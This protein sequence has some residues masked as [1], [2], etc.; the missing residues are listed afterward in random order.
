M[1]NPHPSSFTPLCFHHLF[2]QQ[3]ARHPNAPAILFEDSLIPYAE[4][5]RNANR[6]ARH[7]QAM[8]IG[9]Q[10]LVAISMERAPEMICAILGIFKAGAAWV[11]LDPLLPAARKALILQETGASVILTHRDLARQLPANQATV[12]SLDHGW[13]DKLPQDDSNPASTHPD[14]RNHLAYIIYTSGSTGMPKGVL[15]EQGGLFNLALAQKSIFGV[16]A[17]DRVLQ[18]SSLNFDASIFEIVM[19]L[20]AGATLVLGR[21]EAILPGPDL[22]HFLQTRAVSH[23]TIP[24]SSL[25]NLPQGDLPDLRTL[26]LAGEVL[27]PELAARWASGRRLFNAYGPT[28]TTVWASVAQVAADGSKPTLGFAIPN[29]QL[30]LLDQ[31]QQAVA[32]GEVGEIT[33]GG[34]GVARGY[35]LRPELNRK[36]FLPNPHHPG[37]DGKP[38]SRMYRS[39]DLGRFL[40][41]GSLEFLGRIDQQIKLRGYRI[42]P[43]EIETVLKQHAGVRDALVLARSD[44]SPQSA[45]ASAANTATNPAENLAENSAANPANSVQLL[46]WVIPDP[47]WRAPPELLASWQQE[48]AKAWQGLYDDTYTTSQQELRLEDDFSGWGNS[49]TGQPIPEQEMREWVDACVAPVL[50]LRPQRVL[51]IGCGSGLLARRIAAQ[52]QHYSGIDISAA[53]ISA[54]EQRL[55]HAGIHNVSLAVAAADD[56]AAVMPGRFD[57]IIINSVLQY[58][59]DADYLQQVLANAVRAC[60]PGGFVF[61]GDVRNLRL[62][63]AFYSAIECYQRPHLAGQTQ[64]LRQRIA[65]RARAEEELLVDPAFFCAL[66]ASLPEISHVDIRLRRGKAHNELT[67][68]RYNVLLHVATDP[69]AKPASSSTSATTAAQAAPVFHTPTV[70]QGHGIADLPAILTSHALALIRIPNARLCPAHPQA[71]DP[72]SVAEL[73]SA[74]GYTVHLSWGEAADHFNAWF[75]RG[76]AAATPFDV[77]SHQAL[78]TPPRYTNHPLLLKLQSHL[79]AELRAHL[80]ARLPPHMVPAA[81]VLIDQFP[82]NTSGKVDVNAL[83]GPGLRHGRHQI[84]PR[85]PLE[86]QL[87]AIWCQLLGLESVGIHDNFFE[88]GGHSLLA[89]QLISRISAQCEFRLQTKNIFT[90]PTIAELVTLVQGQPKERHDPILPRAVQLARRGTVADDAAADDAAAALPLSF[91]QQRL[92]FLSQLT[93][94]SPFYNIPVALRLD[95]VLNVAALQRSLDALIARHEILR[96]LFPTHNGQARQQIQP[97]LQITLEQQDISQIEAQAEAIHDIAAEHARAPFDLVLG[98]LLRAKLLRCSLQQDPQQH[99]QQHPQQ[100]RQ[101]Y[102][103]LLLTMHHIISDAWSMAI[104]TRELADFY[105][106]ASKPETQPDPQ[107]DPASAPLAPAPLQYADFALWQR[108]QRDPARMAQELAYWRQRLAGAPMVLELPTDY[109]RPANQAFRGA[110]HTVAISAAKLAQLQALSQDANATLFMTLLAAFNVL[111]WRSSGQSDFL[112]GTPIAGRNRVETE[113]MIGFFVNSL[114]LR[115]DLG[116]DPE[117]RQHL[118]SVKQGALDAFAHKDLP[119]EK[120]VEELRPQ[121]DLSRNALFQVM[122]VLQNAP[123]AAI[124]RAGLRFSPQVIDNHT[125]K[126]DL[127]LTLE[128][129]G[130]GLSA[131]LEYNTDLFSAASAQRMLG[132]YVNLLDAIIRQPDAKVSRL[133]LLGSQEQ[134]QLLHAWNHFEHQFAPQSTIHA[135][136]ETQARTRPDACAIRCGASRLSYAELDQRANRLAHWL[137]AH[138]VTREV[139]V[140]LC[141]ERSPDLIVSLLGI[142]KAGGAYLPMDPAYPPERMAFMLEDSGA[143][144]LLTQQSL[145]ASLPAFG[146]H[147]LCL[148]RDAEQLAAQPTTAPPDHNSAHD[149]AYVI[150]TSGS[151]GQPKGVMITHYNVVRLFQA[152]ADWFHFDQDDVWTLFHS[153]AFDFSVWEIWGALMHGGQLVIV[154]YLLSRSPQQF[155]RLLAEQG[156]T[157]LNQTPAAFYQLIEAEAALSGVAPGNAQTMSDSTLPEL[158]LRQVIF[159]GEALDLSALRPWFARHPVQPQL[160]NMYGITETCV[161]VSY[162]PISAQDAQR[163]AGSLIGLPIPDLQIYLLDAHQQLCP[164]GVTGEIYVGGAGLARGYL[165]RPAL[166]AERF[167][168]DPFHPGARLYRSGDL[169]RRLANGEL[170][171]LGRAD[172]QVKIRGFRIELGEIENAIAKL[173]QVRQALVVVHEDRVHEDSP[174]D[175]RLVAYLLLQPSAPSIEIDPRALRASLKP[176]LPEYMIPSAFVVLPAF[177]LTGNGKV[178]RRALPAP[179]RISASHGSGQYIEPDGA[180]EVALAAIWADLLQQERISADD[181]FFELGGHSLL[182]VQMMSRVRSELLIQAP[183]TCLFEAPTLSAFAA[184]L[185][186]CQDDDASH[187][188]R[189]RRILP[190]AEKTAA[191]C[192]AP[193]SFAQKRLWFIDQ[194][195]PGNPVYN[196]PLAWRLQGPLNPA[197]LEQGLNLIIQRHA[198]LRTR[199][200]YLAGQPEVMQIIAA[201]L[202]LTLTRHNLAEATLQQHIAQSCRSGFDLRQGPLLRATL[203]Q[204]GDQQHVLLLELHHSIADGWSVKI[205]LKELTRA[206]ADFAIGGDCCPDL[207]ALPIQYSD[208]AWWQQEWLQGA[209]LAQQ[210][211]F[212]R[213]E[214]AGAPTVLELPSDHARPAVQSFAGAIAVLQLEPTL[215]PALEQLALRHGV[216]LFMTLAAG[217]GILLSRYTR[218]KDILIGIPSA[219]RSQTEIEAL[220]GYFANSLVLRLRL[221][222]N[223]TLHEYLQQVKNRVL[224]AFAHQDIPFERIVEEIQ[225]TRDLSRNPLFQVLFTLEQGSMPQRLGPLQIAPVQI[226]AAV[227]RVDL[228]LILTDHGDHID[229][230]CEY[231]TDL[232][233]AA[234]IERLLRHYRTILQSMLDQPQARIAELAMISDDERKQILQHWN[235]ASPAANQTNQDSRLVHQLFEARAADQ[236]QQVAL[237]AGAREI[238]F[239]ELN[240]RANQL[241]RHLRQLGVGPDDIVGVL[242]ERSLDVVLAQLAVM[243]AGGAFMPLD[244]HYPQERLAFMIRDSRAKVVISIARLGPMP[245]ATAATAVT[246]LWLDQ[247]NAVIAQLDSHNLNAPSSVTGADPAQQLAYVIYTSGSTGVPKG[248]M[249]QHDNLRHLILWHHAFYPLQAGERAGHLASPS[250]D[251]SVVEIWPVLC[252]GAS[253]VIAED[254]S[255]YD[256]D[257]LKTWLVAQRIKLCFIPTVI[258]EQFLGQPWP[259][260]ACLEYMLTGGEKLTRRPPPGFAPQLINLYGPTE[261]TVTTSCA[262]VWPGSDQDTPSI[263]R[264]ITRSQLYVLDEHDQLCPP[265]VPGELC[266]GGAGV[267]RGYL[268]RADLTAEKF[269]PDPFST[270]AGAR[271]YRSG[272]LCAFAADGNLQFIGRID[273]QVKI[274]GLRIEL[275]EIEIA[276]QQHPAIQDA[277]VHV[278]QDARHEKHLVAWLIASEGGLPGREHLR[279]HLSQHLRQHLPAYMTPSI[280]IQVAAWPTTANGKFDMQALPSPALQLACN[281]T[282]DAPHAPL[283]DWQQRLYPLWCAVLGTAHC[284]VE[285]NFF[286]LGGHSLLAMQLISRIDTQLGLRLPLTEFF[287]NPTLAGVAHYLEWQG[288]GKPGHLCGALLALRTGGQQ[289]P[290]ILVHGAMG[291]A[292][293]FYELARQLGEQQPVYALQAQGLPEAAQTSIESMARLYLAAIRAEGL[294]QGLHGR[295]ILCG[296]SMGGVIAFEMARQ[297]AAEGDGASELIML[298]SWRARGD[299]NIT[300]AAMLEEFGHALLNRIP[301][302]GVEQHSVEQ[303]LAGLLKLGIQRK[304]LAEN[305]AID[306]VRRMFQVYYRNVLAWRSFQAQPWPGMRA[307]LLRTGDYQANEASALLGWESVVEAGEMALR[308]VPGN[309]YTMLQEPHVAV[310]AQQ[311]RELLG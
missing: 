254:E 201:S 36:C 229:G 205:L 128:E 278:W 95:G 199:F 98:P 223:P 68:Y 176:Y 221:D 134:E 61:V 9:A 121:R 308:D 123:L 275:G 64:E 163:G 306:E 122:F 164:L 159:G 50:A 172:F 148:D 84:A 233:E 149:L 263:G 220:I 156:V 307:T 5:N 53:A 237:I 239:A 104:L 110:L 188:T 106:R 4:L 267:G 23:L 88:L 40:P 259:Q 293:P 248:V 258:V 204:E 270:Q 251:A 187:L 166:T 96:T 57:A 48:Q 105:Q 102:H 230:Y 219:G 24:P 127:T 274:R 158:K 30:Y 256:P 82:L 177:P 272:D 143:P 228:A 191:H 101:Q 33:I 138:G 90:H 197:A 52:C 6:L 118:A 269:I 255:R 10:A 59:R 116:E 62:A 54:L 18:F 107:P 195:A 311:I 209:L 31:A 295:C 89:T 70:W 85:N 35:L 144:V 283:T 240:C 160:V 19:A 151:T 281:N 243:K 155:Y 91:A 310:L 217:F 125:A 80:Q 247:E 249:I 245:G 202:P 115:A 252:A 11:P 299:E 193:L 103:V 224:N 94:D 238:S 284:G 39:G 171:Y 192:A 297:L 289:P 282:A 49:F 120:L 179:Q 119:F 3:A 214:L 182:A 55:D 309:H 241:A 81:M 227:S 190:Q 131:A 222:A 285:D 42:E 292:L 211:A 87:A 73:G 218:Q 145:L 265:G 27:S 114:V 286:D 130:H 242:L 12:L 124:E 162:R 109:P 261:T 15:L 161:H 168:D 287:H 152:T 76:P 206:Y 180:I 198:I 75:V 34:A 41:D 135:W 99:P 108:Q 244:P 17:G 264:P 296:W 14:C 250:F 72:E 153:P 185:H 65:R 37:T 26:V 300:E 100:N 288:V 129:T 60:A 165:N 271:L 174:G 301:Q 45:A 231:S 276:L 20:S 56:F 173:P 58:F 203:F 234:T 113:D 47:A 175:K 298:D 216:T 215:K 208:F 78:P 112:L 183:L 303:R 43:G 77:A 38:A 225:P 154:P 28:E 157:V 86:Q 21:R 196:I 16:Q 139:L 66:K 136:L 210:T 167:I 140:A 260:Q 266:I 290:L 150:Y 83:P 111:L 147:L 170:E 277:A 46:A 132:H 8:G 257:K 232:F 207:P 7:L 304:K 142:L 93:P 184:A 302:F 279:Q 51:E 44:A 268:H 189:L 126:F 22:L 74:K 117:F 181:H 226:E 212:W 63:E 253:V 1:S 236:P 137:R 71:L 32:P 194:L 169:A 146:G 2:E 273:H 25:A 97:T 280:F 213:Q 67:C 133:P 186:A 235:H 13:Q 178:D 291:S 305:T 200:D 262:R 69:A 29:V 246:A 79:S 294:H 141:M 92:W